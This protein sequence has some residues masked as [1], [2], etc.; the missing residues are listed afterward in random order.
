MELPAIM[1]VQ[2]KAPKKV[3]T[4]EDLIQ[5]NID[6]FG[7]DIGKTTNWITSMFEVQA[8]FDR[9]S[10]EYRELAYRIRCGQLFQ[11]NAI[12]KTKGIVAKPMPRYWHD[13]HSAAKLED[14]EQR[15]LCLAIVADRKPYFMRLIYP[16]LMRVY[17][18]YI[19]NTNK[20]AMRQ[21]GMTVQELK[22]IPEHSRT[23]RQREFL[24]WYEAK[25]P[26]GTNGCVM[27]RI[28]RRFEREFDGYVGRR[29]PDAPFDYTVMKS[30]CEYT[31]TQYT[32]V[33]ALYKEYMSRLKS[34]CVFAGYERLDKDEV[35]VK[36]MDMRSEF[37]AECAAVCPNRE[38]LCDIVLDI[39]YTKESSKRFAWD[40]CGEDIIRNLLRR[41]GGVISYPTRDEDGEIVY[42]GERFSVRQAVLDHRHPGC[43][44]PNSAGVEESG[45]ALDA[46]TA[47]K[48]T[49]EGIN[50]DSLE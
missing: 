38:V 50:G 26:V 5:S 29:V 10:E 47:S 18:T 8:G 40:M 44:V 43:V 42:C 19:K 48:W 31:R 32:S 15:R 37:E 35:A 39:C 21:F 3:V 24:H 14:Q 36:L 23:Q 49:Q 17:N 41:N 1:C 13:R 4:E 6:S 12:D 22:A 30:G 46:Q 45:T 9:D 7:D 2:R 28:C 11:Q 25:L 20:N 27:N 34:C 33:L 16:D